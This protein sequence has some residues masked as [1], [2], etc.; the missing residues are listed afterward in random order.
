MSDRAAVPATP[1]TNIAGCVLERMNEV[2][3][4]DA[5]PHPLHAPKING[6]AWAYVKDCLDTGWVSSVGG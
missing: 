5:G 1:D 3:P 6:N 4:R 2:L